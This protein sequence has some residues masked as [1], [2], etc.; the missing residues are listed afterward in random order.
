MNNLLS[1]VH[2]G[3][4]VFADPPSKPETSS[5]RNLRPA[6]SRAPPWP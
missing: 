4:T 6:I 2:P 5:L 3:F 1:W